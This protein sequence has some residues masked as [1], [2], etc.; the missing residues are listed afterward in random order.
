M[1]ALEWF[2]R[3]F[4]WTV[5]YNRSDCVVTPQTTALLTSRRKQDFQ[6]IWKSWI[7]FDSWFCQLD[8][9]NL[10]W[11]YDASMVYD[12]KWTW[13]FPEHP[14]IALTLGGKYPRLEDRPEG[15]QMMLQGQSL[16]EEKAHLD[17]LHSPGQNVH[18]IQW[19]PCF[20]PTMEHL[21]WKVDDSMYDKDAWWRDS[22]RDYA[23]G[24]SP[25]LL[26]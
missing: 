2:L 25:N 26:E 22:P 4:W 3:R 21:Y 13:E 5:P 8:Q 12:Q 16:S 7:W 23:E 10:N 19:E 11:M 20:R 14:R 17:P 15:D 18:W 24:L 1:P 9:E 6:W